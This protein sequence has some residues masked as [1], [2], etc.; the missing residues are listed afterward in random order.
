MTTSRDQS[1]K[2]KSSF[3]SSFT[4][5]HFTSSCTNELFLKT[6]YLIFLSLTHQNPDFLSCSQGTQICILQIAILWYQLNALPLE[7]VSYSQINRLE[8]KTFG[9]I[10]GPPHTQ[11][12]FY[13]S[14]WVLYPLHKIKSKKRPKYKFVTVKS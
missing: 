8:D 6:T 4:N 11:I 7:L 12:V 3:F 2:D 13:L 5:Q 10:K 14:I 9:S 1:M